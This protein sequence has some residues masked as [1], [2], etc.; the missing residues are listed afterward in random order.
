VILAGPQFSMAGKE[1]NR[2]ERACEAA[3]PKKP[4]VAPDL[5]DGVQ[6]HPQRLEGVNRS[7]GLRPGG[8]ELRALQGSG[9]ERSSGA[10]S[11]RKLA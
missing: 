11:S 9:L 10:R 2:I 5:R 7:F 8:P 3:E 1:C 4:P 6:M